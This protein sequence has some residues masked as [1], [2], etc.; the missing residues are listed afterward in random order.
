MVIDTTGVDVGE[1]TLVLESF[2]EDSNGVES[3]L[4]TDTIQIVI[5]EPELELELEDSPC[6]D[7]SQACFLDNLEFATIFSGTQSEWSLPE[8]FVGNEALID[9]LIKYDSLIAPYLS[10]DSQ[11]NEI[12]YDGLQINSLT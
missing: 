4:K 1:H 2:D 9:V 8:I 7:S 6:E 3:T 5:T 10:Y 12:S 11:K